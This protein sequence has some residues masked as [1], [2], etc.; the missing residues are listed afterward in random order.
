MPSPEER[1]VLIACGTVAGFICLMPGDI[2]SAAF[3]W[4]CTL[5]FYLVHRHKLNSPK[6][7]SARANAES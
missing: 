2:G 1:K 7:S 4:A 6:P 5:A 3:A